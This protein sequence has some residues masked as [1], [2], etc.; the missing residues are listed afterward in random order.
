MV[1]TTITWI[2]AAHL[3]QAPLPRYASEHTTE[4]A[5][6]DVRRALAQ[7][8]AEDGFGIDCAESGKPDRKSLI[9]QVMRLVA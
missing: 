8:I 5:F 6:A 1:A 3:K 9:A 2:Y 7:Q 4:Y